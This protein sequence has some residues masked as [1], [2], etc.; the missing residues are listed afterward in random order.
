MFVFPC[1]R[2]AAQRARLSR[3]RLLGYT[4]HV[5]ATHARAR[6]SLI[7]QNICMFFV[8]E[9]FGDAVGYTYEDVWVRFEQRAGM[10]GHD[11]CISTHVRGRAEKEGVVSP[12]EHPSFYTSGLSTHTCIARYVCEP[13]T[14]VK[15]ERSAHPHGTRHTIMHRISA[16]G[17]MV[18]IQPR[19]GYLL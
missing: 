18:H 2:T 15:G 17:L 1:T 4:V 14:Y 9:G 10:M 19:V 8:K 11:T 7:V 12:N 6:R 13:V 16:L 5:A 3:P